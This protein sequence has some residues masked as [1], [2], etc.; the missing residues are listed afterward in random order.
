M[1]SWIRKF[2]DASVGREISEAVNDGDL[3]KVRECV[4]IAPTDM[5]I[6]H[7]KRYAF[8]CDRFLSCWEV[9]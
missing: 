1:N 4:C 3:A 6:T 7:R 2:V 9:H 5:L 8:A